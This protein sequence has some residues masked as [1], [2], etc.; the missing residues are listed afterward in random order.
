MIRRLKGHI[1]G[2]SESH[3][4]SPEQNLRLMLL[5]YS[6]YGCFFLPLQASW[7]SPRLYYLMYGYPGPGRIPALHPVCCKRL[8]IHHNPD[9]GKA[10]TQH[11]WMYSGLPCTTEPWLHVKGQSCAKLNKNVQCFILLAFGMDRNC[12]LH[13]L[14]LCVFF[15]FPEIN[16]KQIDH[17][18]TFFF[19]LDIQYNVSM[20]IIRN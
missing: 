1:P 18:L 13:Q 10:I 9:Q 12:T 2:L 20:K 6:R 17:S 14:C 4:W 16:N 7:L 15:L 8:W 11:E 19:L 5:L 3:C